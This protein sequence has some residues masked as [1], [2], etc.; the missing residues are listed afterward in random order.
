MEAIFT[1]LIFIEAYC[2]NSALSDFESG[3][4]SRTVSA[5]RFQVARESE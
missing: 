2:G 3:N 5:L 1:G 4:S